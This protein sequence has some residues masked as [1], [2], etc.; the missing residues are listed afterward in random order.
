MYPLNNFKA[1]YIFL[2]STNKKAIQRAINFDLFLFLLLL[3]IT[4]ATTTFNFTTTFKAQK[5]IHN[6]YNYI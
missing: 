1:F 6:K 5:Y 2:D 4:Q 3:R